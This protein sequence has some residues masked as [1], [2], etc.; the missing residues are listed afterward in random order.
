[1]LPTIIS[2]PIIPAVILSIAI[3][4]RT[5]RREMMASRTLFTRS[6]SVEVTSFC[7]FCLLYQIAYLVYDPNVSPNIRMIPLGLEA[8]AVAGLF[9]LLS[10][11]L[12]TWLRMPKAQIPYNEPK[13]DVL[14]IQDGSDS[15]HIGYRVY[16]VAILLLGVLLFF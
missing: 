12:I 11:G 13:I 4:Y 10:S 5:V 2:F 14:D 9:F 6:F 7:I 16:F 15:A 3:A 8:I 1:M